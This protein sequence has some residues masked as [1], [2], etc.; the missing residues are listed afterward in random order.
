[1]TRVW[2]A[3]NSLESAEEATV[4]SEDPRETASEKRDLRGDPPP[5]VV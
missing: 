3:S 5:L 1:V 4:G 2:A